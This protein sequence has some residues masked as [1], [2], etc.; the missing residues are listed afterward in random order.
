MYPQNNVRELFS[1]LKRA[2][3][4]RSSKTFVICCPKKIQNLQLVLSLNNLGS[5]KLFFRQTGLQEGAQIILEL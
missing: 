1:L 2:T 3:Y 5:V 4:T